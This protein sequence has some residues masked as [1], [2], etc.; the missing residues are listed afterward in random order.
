M[1]NFLK[2]LDKKLFDGD[3]H[4]A[5]H[6]KY[7]EGSARSIVEKEYAAAVPALTI[8]FSAKEKKLLK[9]MEGLFSE[10]RAYV[11][12]YSYQAGVFCGFCEF[13][14]QNGQSE[15]G[16]FSQYVFHELFEQPRSQKHK[17]YGWV[18]RCNE[19]ETILAGSVSS[20]IAEHITSVGVAWENRVYYAALCAFY[21][22][23]QSALMITETINP[24]FTSSNRKRMLLLGLA[25]NI[26]DN[27]E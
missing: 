15:D 20:E 9:E 8:A 25:L 11:S 18:N 10:I 7:I 21:M 26:E 19:I 13:H 2:S 23:Y 22:G 6:K 14:I 1:T 5:I 16:G 17:C 24:M 27:T 3:F 12:E 4:E